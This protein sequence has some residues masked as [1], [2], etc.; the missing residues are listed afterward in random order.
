[1]LE[2]GLAGTLQEAA[3]V[4]SVPLRMPLRAYTV[5][6]RCGSGLACAS[7][8]HRLTRGVWA[9]G[10]RFCGARES[11]ALFAFR[12]ACIWHIGIFIRGLAVLL[13][14]FHLSERKCERK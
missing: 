1:V 4:F 5:C 13:V 6:P 7:H 9:C 2:F 11:L 8:T 12:C 3:N 10:D 14:A